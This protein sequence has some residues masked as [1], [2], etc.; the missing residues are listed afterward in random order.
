MLLSPFAPENLVPGDGFGRPVP[1][2]S[3]PFSPLRPNVVLT[4][5][6]PSAFHD[7][8]HLPSTA[9]GSVP[10]LSGHVIVNGWHSLPRVHRHRASGP[11]GS[12]SNECCLLRYITMDHFLRASLLGVAVPHLPKNRKRSSQLYLFIYTVPGGCPY[13]LPL[14]VFECIHF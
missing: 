13:F 4:H 10:R 7:R 2:Q 11:Q 6:I 14:H 3:A 5:G 9:I 1:R 8:V 12:S